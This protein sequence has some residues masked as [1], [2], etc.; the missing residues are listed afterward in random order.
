MA[1]FIYLSNDTSDV[2]GY[3]KAYVNMRSP[4]A[5][6]AYV[7]ST[8]TVAA[9]VLSS[10]ADLT[11]TAGGSQAVWITEEFKSDVEISAPTLNNIWGGEDASGTN[12]QFAIRLAEYTTSE[13]SAFYTTSNGVEL[14][15]SSATRVIWAGGGGRD[16]GES[17]PT[18]TTIDAGN[19]LVVD[20]GYTGVTGGD[21]NTAAGTVSFLYGATAGTTGDTYVVL[22]ESVQIG[23]TQVGASGAAPSIPDKGVS[24]FLDLENTVQAAVDAGAVTSDAT[25]QAII[26]E[27]AEQALLS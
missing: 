24:Y 2:S 23:E 13:Q 21:G 12:A 25:A 8:T 15:T 22:N 18:G 19:R 7:H 5:T 3:L 20:P 10:T 27:A 11:L 6:S 16:N 17:D 9:G 26:D 14:G 4:S 1:T